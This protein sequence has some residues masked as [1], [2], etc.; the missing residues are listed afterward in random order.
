MV[1][2]FSFV[3]LQEARDFLDSMEKKTRKKV[4]FNIWKSKTIIDKELF[5]HLDGNIYE[6]R[7]LFNK[8]YIRLFAFWDKE[9]NKNTLV[10]GTHGI[11][12]TTA[13]VPKSDIKKAERIRTK[14]FESKNIK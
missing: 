6:F 14:Y 13:K 1:E 4:M 7:T 3:A 5:E 2:R 11:Y 9:D 12:K 8:K 10:V